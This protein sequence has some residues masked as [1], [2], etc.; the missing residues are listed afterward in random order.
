MST[1]PNRPAQFASAALL[2]AALWAGM[3]FRSEA[4]DAPLVRSAHGGRWSAADTWEGGKVPPAGAR[5]QIRP[6]HV[7]VYDRQ[8]DEAIRDLFIAGVLTFDPDRDTRLDVGLI[9]IQ[10]G[11]DLREEGFDCD[12]PPRR[13]R[14]RSAAAG[15]DRRRGRPSHRREAHGDDP[16]RLL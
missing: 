11:D 12:R 5:V 13:T 2:F 9:R 16:A 14:P 10:A 6:G 15:P 7:I 8:S 1:L 3:T 4:A